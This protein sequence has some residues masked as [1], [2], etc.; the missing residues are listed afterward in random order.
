MD[1]IPLA[2]VPDSR[3]Q[4]LSKPVRPL[5]KKPESD[6]AIE[7]SKGKK[8]I[9]FMALTED[10]EAKSYRASAKKFFTQAVLKL[11]RRHAQQRKHV[12]TEK[13]ETLVNGENQ[14]L[15][16]ELWIIVAFPSCRIIEGTHKSRP[17]RLLLGGTKNQE[18]TKC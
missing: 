2:K 6:E 11:N 9:E 8:K 13:G 7:M 15:V 4:R 14:T 16:D 5:T 1:N 10:E 18:M 3:W 17:I 12:L